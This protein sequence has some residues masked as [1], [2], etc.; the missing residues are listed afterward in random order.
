MRIWRVNDF[1]QISRLGEPNGAWGLAAAPEL[2]AD[3]PPEETPAEEIEEQ[4][5]EDEEIEKGELVSEE[6]DEEPD[7]EQDDEGESSER[8]EAG[9]FGHQPE[10]QR[11]KKKHGDEHGT[12]AD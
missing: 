10:Q 8:R 1:A 5:E 12:T 6:P 4:D 2:N 3:D 7:E 9:H 11:L